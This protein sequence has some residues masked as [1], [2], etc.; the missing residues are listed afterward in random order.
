MIFCQN[1]NKKVRKNP[2]SAF[3]L[4]FVLI[5]CTPA[6]S[7]AQTV[8]SISAA[9]KIALGIE[10]ENVLPSESYARSAVT[11]VVVAPQGSS[12]P[13]T[14]PF[15]GIMIKPLV[16]PGM[17][18]EKGQE[19]A[20]LHSPE[21]ATAKA[22]LG[23]LRLT[24]VHN[25]HLYEITEQLFEI[26]LRSELELD[27]AIHEMES[28]RLEFSAMADLLSSVL[29]G[30]APGQFVLTS[31]V[32]GIV[33]NISVHQGSEV[34]SS[35]A[36]L[37]I[38][39]GSKYWARVQLPETAATQVTLQTKVQLTQTDALGIVVAVNPE[40][41]P[42]SRSL[43]VIVELPDEDHWRIGQLISA[44]FLSE[45]NPETQALPEQSI[46]RI[47]GNTFVFVEEPSGF[48]LTP[49]VIA[50]RSRNLVIVFGD[51]AEG[52][53]VAISGIAALKNIVEGA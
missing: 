22:E 48:R 16:F 51:L 11:G 14:S 24:M 1:K 45:V 8:I 37:T 26:G 2:V 43:E 38:F 7:I 20:L 28:A 25:E 18:V 21:Y 36:L 17:S 47:G 53:R 27:E 46:V 30:D 15:S 31:S 9:N 5:L 39:E 12:F 44:S 34:I 19:I 52:D 13:I 3:F 33:S 40:I 10:T 49:V 32:D 50:S 35:S 29:P 23:T 6:I 41:D 4:L 42:V